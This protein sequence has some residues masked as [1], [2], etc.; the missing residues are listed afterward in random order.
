MPVKLDV[1]IAGQQRKPAKQP[2]RKVIQ[3]LSHLINIVEAR[4][5]ASSLHE[6]VIKVASSYPEGALDRIESMP[7]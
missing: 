5:L 2:A 1:G 6:A 3:S 7:I 4:N